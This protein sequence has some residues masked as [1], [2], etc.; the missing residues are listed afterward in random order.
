[1]PCGSGPQTTHTLA[2]AGPYLAGRRVW[3]YVL[4]CAPQRMD[5][6]GHVWMRL[7]VVPLGTEHL[8]ELC[9]LTVRR[10]NVDRIAVTLC[11]SAS[12]PRR[13]QFSRTAFGLKDI[14]Q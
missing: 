2:R 3:E 1:M 5:N 13:W 10:V 6:T 7:D 14:E 8:V 4:P 9:V 11:E 12:P